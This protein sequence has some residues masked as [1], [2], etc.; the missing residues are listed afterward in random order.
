M[1][2]FIIIHEKDKKT[3]SLC[4]K[5]MYLP[6]TQ[7][8]FCCDKVVLLLGDKVSHVCGDG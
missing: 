7:S 1:Y 5:T 4:Q 6:S 8:D 3:V 2:Y